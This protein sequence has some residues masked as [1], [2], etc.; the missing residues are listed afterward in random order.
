M[1]ESGIAPIEIQKHFYRPVCNPEEIERIFNVKNGR[2]YLLKLRADTIVDDMRLFRVY[3]NKALLD[4]SKWSLERSFD[5]NHYTAFLTA[6]PK[7]ERTKCKETTYGNFFSTDP[8]GSIFKTTYGP[9]ITISDALKFFLKFAHLAILDFGEVVPMYVRVNALRIAIRVMLGSEALDFFMDPRGIVPNS[10]GTAMEKPIANQMEFIAGH[11][12]A[13][14]LLGHLSDVNLI[15]RPVRYAVAL[16]T[17]D[18]KLIDV[19]CQSQ[20][21]EL[22]ADIFAV[23]APGYSSAKR[24]RI[25]ECALLWFGCY[26]LFEIVCEAL[27]PKNPY[28]QQDH[29]TARERYENLLSNISLNSQF[30]LGIWKVFP[31]NIE[32]LKRILI[33]DVTA[34]PNRYIS[35]GSVYLDV[36]NSKWR[37]RELIDRV[38]YY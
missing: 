4:E 10:I 8:N 13:H 1:D 38:D 35:Y 6:L 25:L 29:P 16:S 18:T 3:R 33:E 14:H 26:E 21:D 23:R 12:F 36:P 9:I 15:S 30:D 17:T 11:E 22:D 19:F 34:D 5:S 37:G 2:D 24:M 32:A 27:C 28:S 20:Q 7:D 31:K